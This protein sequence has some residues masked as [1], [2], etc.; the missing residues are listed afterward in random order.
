MTKSHTTNGHN[1]AKTQPSFALT[2]PN[3]SAPAQPKAKANGSGTN[4]ATRTE[5]FDQPVVLQQTSVWSR[6]IVWG[7]VSVTTFVVIWASV[8]KIEEAVPATGKLEP[9]GSVQEV[10]VP[11]GG[12]VEEV[13]VED[14]QRVEKGELLVR[15]DP[16]AA[17]AQRRSLQQVR[18]SLAQEVRF[19]R[20]QLSGATQASPDEGVDLPAEILSLTENRAALVAENNLYRSQLRGSSAGANLTPEQQE[21]LQAIAAEADSRTAAAQLQ[22]LQSQREYNQV[23]IQLAAAQQSLAI[24]QAILG[25]IAP[26]VEEGAI[27]RLQKTRQEQEVLNARA[28]VNRLAQEKARLELAIAEAQQQLQNTM[29]VSSTELLSRISDNDKQIAT[30][31]SELNKAIVENEKQIADIDSQ[32]SQTEL[33]LRY[34]ELRAPVD[35]VVFDLQTQIQGVVNQGA[36]EPILKIVPDDS[37]IAKVTITNQDI[38]FVGENQEVDVRIDSFPYSEFGDIEGEL[39]WIGSDA[40]PPTEITPF[41][42]F[43]AKIRLEE[44]ALNVGGREI[45]LQSGM[46]VTVNIKVRQRTVMSIFTEL[47]ADKVNS[48]RTVR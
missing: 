44:Q 42:T 13:L 15:L 27:G 35:G 25:D 24:D 48:L 11:V 36:P 46:S 41:Y 39:V 8:A 3:G 33:N 30:I 43:P 28:E 21:R 6:A 7:I 20:A 4:Q 14:G 1:G 9:Q 26:L 45:A 32:L 2:S 19:Y 17:E 16:T 47:F 38:G 40:L 23:D 22:L 18:N 37:L 10:E 34:Q 29:A 5:A 12:V 31:N